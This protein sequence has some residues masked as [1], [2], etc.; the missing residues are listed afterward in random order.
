MIK[1]EK[2]E[3]IQSVQYCDY[4]GQKAQHFSDRCV[5]CDKAICQDCVAFINEIPGEYPNY[6]C[7]HCWEI[8]NQYHSDIVKMKAK[9][10][11][12]LRVWKKEVKK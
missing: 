9:I 8:G 4:C 2:V 6:Y 1:H 3:I 7:K 10:N 11:D 5:I 12:L